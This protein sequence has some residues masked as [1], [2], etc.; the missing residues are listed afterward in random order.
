MAFQDQLT[1]FVEAQE[2]ALELTDTLEDGRRA[3][4]IRITRGDDSVIVPCRAKVTDDAPR[5]A[6]LH[7][8]LIACQVF[9]QCDDFL[10]WVD[11]QGLDAADSQILH[12]FRELD[13]AQGRLRALIGEEAFRG[14][15]T[16]MEIDQAIGAAAGL[17]QSQRK[18]DP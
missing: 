6:L 12:E 9:D 4:G 7:A 8:A 10:E 17:R 13:G 15:M 14:L 18:D 5:S 11:I 1:E 3:P 16:A 2:I